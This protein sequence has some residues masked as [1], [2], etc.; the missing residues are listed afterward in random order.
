MFYLILKK[1]IAHSNDILTL[2]NMLPCIVFTYP[3][4]VLEF[5]YLMVILY[6][7]KWVRIFCLALF[8]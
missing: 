3:T 1:R 5:M 7:T 4:I 8:Y 6:L 2:S